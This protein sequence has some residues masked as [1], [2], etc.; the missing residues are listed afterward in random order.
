MMMKAASANASVC[1]TEIMTLTVKTDEK[2]HNGICHVPVG[3]APT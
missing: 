1:D 2:P 3:A